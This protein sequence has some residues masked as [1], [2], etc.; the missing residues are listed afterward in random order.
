MSWSYIPGSLLSELKEEQVTE[1]KSEYLARSHPWRKIVDKLTWLVI[2][3][4]ETGSSIPDYQVEEV[5]SEPEYLEEAN[6]ISSLIP[7]TCG[8][9]FLP[10]KCEGGYH[11]VVLDLDVPHVVVPSSTPGHSHLYIDV[12]LK[13]EKYLKLLAAL[14]DCGII[15]TGYFGVSM[16]RR[17]T[18]VRTPWTTKGSF[19]MVG[20]EEARPAPAPAPEWTE[21]EAAAALE[22]ALKANEVHRPAPLPRGPFASPMNGGSHEGPF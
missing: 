10:G 3:K 7:N 9:N 2:K 11:K 8:L 17:A 5:E 20:S 15:E 16:E 18:H 6:M 21:D 4:R 13:W 14:E 22:I 19:P 12:D 1:Q